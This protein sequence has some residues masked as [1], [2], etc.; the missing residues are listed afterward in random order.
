VTKI[1]SGGFSAVELELLRDPQS[2]KVENW[3]ADNDIDI[4]DI[5]LTERYYLS[6]E[7]QMVKFRIEKALENYPEITVEWTNDLP[8]LNAKLA[9][10]KR[11]DLTAELMAIPGL[12]NI[13]NM[14]ESIE[15]EELNT[16]DDDSPVIL[17][18]LFE[19]SLAKIESTE[20]E[21]EQGKSELTETAKR[22][23]DA[24]ADYMSSAITLSKK[25]DLNV[26]LI[27]LGASDSTGTKQFN[28]ALSRKRAQ[29]AQQY[30]SSIGIDPGYLNAI[31]LGVVEIKATGASAR[32]VIFNV[33]KFK[34]E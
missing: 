32:K 21:Y 12:T 23:L 28:Q 7:P 17:N 29:I 3:L 2:T 34:T 13:A 30:L 22:K 14:V 15:I 1:N 25:L 6:L 10:S 18:A 4:S 33:V 27:V 9:N 31:G 5:I 24:L 20:I 26:G 19:I 11:V 8:T 16:L